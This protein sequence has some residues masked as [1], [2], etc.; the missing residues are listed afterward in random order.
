VRDELT[1]KGLAAVMGGLRWRRVNL[2]EVG[3]WD[4]LVDDG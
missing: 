1:W 4:S 2:G 3:N